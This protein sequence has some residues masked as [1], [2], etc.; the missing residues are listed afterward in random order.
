MGPK[1]GIVSAGVE[2]FK[3]DSLKLFQVLFNFSD[4]AFGTDTDEEK[5]MWITV[6]RKVLQSKMMKHDYLFATLFLETGSRKISSTGS[7]VYP[8][9]SIFKNTSHFEISPGAAF[10]VNLKI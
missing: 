3:K 5:R 10:G 8:E 2:F 6:E 7:K 9:N 1:I 4:G